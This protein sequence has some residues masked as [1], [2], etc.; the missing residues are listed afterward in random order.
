MRTHGHSPKLFEVDELVG[1]SDDYQKSFG[2]R[3]ADPRV[4]ALLPG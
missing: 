1:R 2:T 4:V 3:V